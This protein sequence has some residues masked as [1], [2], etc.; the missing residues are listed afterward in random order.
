MCLGRLLK[1]AKRFMARHLAITYVRHFV[2]KENEAKQYIGWTNVPV[3]QPKMC[4][5]S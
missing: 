1:E 2:T 4:R 3:I 5:M